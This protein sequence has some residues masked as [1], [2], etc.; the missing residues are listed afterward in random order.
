MGVFL[1]KDKQVRSGWIL[2]LVTL[3]AFIIT[4]LVSVG[5]MVAYIIKTGVTNVS[6][7]VEQTQGS[8]GITLSLIQ[9]AAF[10]LAPII[11]W[12]FILKR[13]LASMGLSSI[14]AHGK[15]LLAGLL[16]GAIS[17]SVVFGILVTSGQAKVISW[18]PQFSPDTIIY[19]LL[20][21][22][23]GFSEEIYARGFIMSTLR[24]TKSVP[25][26]VIVSA[27]I[28][29]LLHSLNPGM[30]LIPYVNL[31]LV[32]VLFSYMYLLSGNIWMCIG[33]HITWNYF[34]GN[35]FGFLVSGTGTKGLL[36][37]VYEKPTIIN[38]G[39]F[40]PEGGLIVTF[41]ILAGFLMVRYYYR[42]KE[43][44]FVQD[45]FSQVQ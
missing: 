4:F 28:F 9:Q 37:T 22:A 5:F 25:L 34:Q 3:T 11:A 39:A 27:V 32:G 19:L 20:F 12:R 6:E 7:L 36:T 40:G 21:I 29:S 33:Y 43:Y 14:R 26:A 45:T 16:F 8:L 35:V 18:M 15:D 41:I 17:I 24:Q 1:N 2:S 23:V 13:S 31:F 42:K 38:G 30:G 10:I 44:C